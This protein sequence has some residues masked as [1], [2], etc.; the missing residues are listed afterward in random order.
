VLG[1]KYR[2]PGPGQPGRVL[3]A[4]PPPGPPFCQAGQQPQFA[5]GLAQLK[6]R[7]GDTMGNLV[8][9][10]HTNADSGDSLLQTTTGLA[11]YHKATNTPTFTNGFEHWAVTDKALV[12]WMG[13]SIDPPPNA[14][15]VP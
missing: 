7:V 15:P 10:E 6:A 3:P 1:I 4:T 9:C 14:T 2:R 5:F 11:F 12:N 13:D 8:E